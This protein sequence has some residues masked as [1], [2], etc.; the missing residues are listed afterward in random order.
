[1]ARYSIKQI[2][3]DKDFIDY[4]GCSTITGIPD[5]PF[6]RAW[7]VDKAIEYIMNNAN[8]KLG[9]V[10]TNHE[11][12]Q[13]M[14]AKTVWEC[15]E[16]LL[17]QARY[18]HKTYLN[19]TA[20]IGKELH[21]L[22]ETF[23]NIKLLYKDGEYIQY[24]NFPTPVLVFEKKQKDFMGY[25][26]KQPYKLKQMFYQFY[27]WQAINVKKFLESE[28]PV[29]HR[30]L[31]FAGT[32]D[33]IYEGFDGKIYCVDLK[34]SGAI[35]KEHEL[36]VVG[37][38]YGRESM[39][40][41]ESII[42]DTNGNYSEKIHPAKF[43]VRFNQD[44][45]SWEKT[46]EYPLIKIDNCAILRISRDYFDLEFKV[47]KYVECKFEA[48]KHLLGYYYTSTDHWTN[49]KYRMKGNIRAKERR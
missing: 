8:S 36:Q 15:D 1:M 11:F 49:S 46:F 41:V 12:G 2:D 35:Y 34:T 43:E 26:S 37:Y 32:L 17:N 22:V 33:F 20:D 24:E 38:K 21:K 27:N 45:N 19:Q 10:V 29:C 5:K 4:V 23:I 47:I 31:C 39:R 7:A 9:N 28:K 3:V 42:A 40:I 13:T 16:Q 44:G 48:F 25:I 30:E 6:L 18:A 14:C